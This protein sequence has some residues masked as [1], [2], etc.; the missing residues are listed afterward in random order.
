MLEGLIRGKSGGRE[1]QGAMRRRRSDVKTM[2]I[3]TALL[4]PFFF[5]LSEC[6]PCGSASSWTDR[7]LCARGRGERLEAVGARMRNLPPPG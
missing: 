6:R 2:M 5:S 3:C 7:G 1:H 4:L